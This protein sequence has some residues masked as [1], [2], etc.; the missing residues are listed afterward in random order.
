MA[1]PSKEQLEKINAH[2]LTPMGE[3]DCEVIENRMID[4]MATSYYSKVQPKLLHKFS[5]DAL[6]GIAF[7]LSHDTRKLP[8]G[9]SFD[10]SV[11]SEIVDDE[12]VLTVYADFYIPS[13]LKLENSL[14]TGDIVK[15]IETGVYRDT[16]IGFSATRWDCS[17]CGNDIRSFWDCP[18]L[19]GRDYIVEDE[20]GN[21]EIETCYVLVGGDGKGSLNESS[22]VY[23][24]ACNRARITAYSAE[25]EFKEGKD[26]SLVPVTNFKDIPAGIE[27]YAQYSDGEFSV[28]TKEGTENTGGTEYL[29]EKGEEELMLNQLREE[30]KSVGI[31]FE[32]IEEFRQQFKENF[33]DIGKYTQ[34][35]AKLAEAGGRKVALDQDIQK[36]D[37]E[38]AR[39]TEENE[40]LKAEKEE[41]THQA[42][43]AEEYKKDLI[44]A[45][46]ELGVAVN[47]NAFNQEV[48]QKLFDAMST[49]ELKEVV[50]A[51]KQQ[52]VDKFAGASV[53]GE[54]RSIKS[55]VKDTTAMYRDDFD[56]EH[57]YSEYVAQKAV[58]FAKEKGISLADATKE[59]YKKFLKEE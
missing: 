40:A 13:G 6:G 27:L 55:R 7:M 25:G 32:T 20:E 19:P 53:A 52:K 23:K 9:R 50:A 36:K 2:S 26:T 1:K 8:L 58:D 45:A 30:F 18:H 37:A 54:N 21:K 46:L 51:F 29:K 28:Y 12:E 35:V 34:S 3:D 57:E 5:Q 10:A 43:V 39:L 31:E 16:S 22:L 48:H 11:V 15:G 24:G 49:E 42:E 44:T 14:T 17:I 59:M 4:S 47:G 41:L 38:I 33:V 56:A